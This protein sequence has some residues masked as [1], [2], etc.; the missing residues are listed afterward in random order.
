[1][2]KLPSSV[3]SVPVSATIGPC[4]PAVSFG[5]SGPG[6]AFVGGYR[7]TPSEQG[8]TMKEVLN[9]NQE[10]RDALLSS[11]PKLDMGGFGS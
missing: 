2:K 6:G 1:M 10:D 3:S 7:Q 5:L 8:L 4:G 9:M 11:L